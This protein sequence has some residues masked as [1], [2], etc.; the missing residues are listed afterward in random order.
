MRQVW[1]DNLDLLLFQ[2]LLIYFL[3]SIISRKTITMENSS[4]FIKSNILH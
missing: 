2:E 1:T 3:F 4:S